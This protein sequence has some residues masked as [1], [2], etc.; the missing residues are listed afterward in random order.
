MNTKELVTQMDQ[1]VSQGEIINAGEQFFAPSLTTNDYGNLQTSSKQQ[2]LEKLNG[3]LGAIATVNGI[4][5]HQTLVDGS[6][7]AS[8]F[9]FDFDMKDGSKILW[10]EIIKRTWENGQVIEEVYFNAN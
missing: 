7:S 8:E 10:H 1:L 6:H 3:F 2:T 5:H 4:T 9:T